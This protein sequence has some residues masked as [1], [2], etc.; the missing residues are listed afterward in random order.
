MERIHY[1]IEESQYEGH[2]HPVHS[3]GNKPVLNPKNT[4]SQRVVKVISEAHFRGNNPKE[5]SREIVDL[6]MK[7]YP[8]R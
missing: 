1:V 8:T 4:V 7:P 6:Q 3:F 2:W 5:I